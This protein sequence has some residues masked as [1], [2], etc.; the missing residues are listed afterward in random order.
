MRVVY[1]PEIIPEWLQTSRQVL[2]LPSR[3]TQVINASGTGTAIHGTEHYSLIEEELRKDPVAGYRVRPMPDGVCTRSSIETTHAQD[4]AWHRDFKQA[5]RY[6][7]CAS[8]GIHDLR[9]KTKEVN[10]WNFRLGIFGRLHGGHVGNSL[11]WVRVLR[12]VFR[13]R[14]ECDQCDNGL[15]G[16]R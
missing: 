13:K 5:F 9:G 7:I 16:G 14:P 10:C 12:S 2:T 3:R 8:C 6:W 11:Y 4:G 15:P 1:L